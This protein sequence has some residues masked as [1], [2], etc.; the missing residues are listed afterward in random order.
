[1]DNIQNYNI[2]YNTNFKLEIP[3]AKTV[4]YFFQQVTLPSIS[5][6]GQDLYYKHNQTVTYNNVTE[7]S[8]LNGIILMDEDFE[9][10]IYLCN[11][12][13]SFIDDDDWRN[14]VK[15]IKLFILSRKQNYSINL[16]ILWCISNNVR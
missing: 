3:Q 1:M 6:M 7:W 11:W 15:D 14:L 10:Y 12:M 9:N 4:N 13:R 16:Y 8:P 2:T 5:N